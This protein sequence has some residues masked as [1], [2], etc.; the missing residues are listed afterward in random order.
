MW[1]D[2]AHGTHGMIL[3]YCRNGSAEISYLG[4]FIGYFLNGYLPD[5]MG[6]VFWF[7]LS[8][9]L[10]SLGGSTSGKVYSKVREKRPAFR[11]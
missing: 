2:G 3:D 1:V 5:L 10:I 7:V 4:S 6:S 11:P 9:L 8:V